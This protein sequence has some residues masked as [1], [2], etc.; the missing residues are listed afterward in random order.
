MV[1]HTVYWSKALKIVP[2][3]LLM[4]RIV[5]FF[6][7][8]LFHLGIKLKLKWILLSVKAHDTLKV[9]TQTV[10]ATLR[11]FSNLCHLCLKKSREN[12]DNV[13]IAH[14]WESKNN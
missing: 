14:F 12:P 9:H 11:T 8:I 3:F 7:H 13:V 10:Y 5:V 2:P 6:P 4:T 1:W